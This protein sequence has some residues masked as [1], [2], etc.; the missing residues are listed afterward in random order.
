MDKIK[1]FLFGSVRRQLITSVALVHAIM[2]TLFVADLTARQ[3]DFLLERQAEQARSIAD[4]VAVS[5]GV[6]LLSR[7]LTGLQEIID[8]QSQHPGLIFAMAVDRDGLI[9]A[10]TERE[11]RGQYI[12]DIPSR[13]EPT[14]IHLAA[15]LTDVLT[16]VQIKNQHVGWIRI[17]LEQGRGLTQSKALTRNGLFY[18]LAA[19]LIGAVIAAYTGTRLTRKLRAIRNT[20]DAIKSGH[21][22]ARAPETGTDEAAVLARD[23]NRMLDTLAQNSQELVASHAALR[24]NEAYLNRVL[25]GANDGAWEWDMKTNHVSYSP[26]WKSML[27]Y[28]ENELAP[29]LSTW[30]KLCHPDDV[31]E[32]MQ[33]IQEYVDGKRNS[34]QIE[35]RMMHK[36]GHWVPVL[37]RGSLV[38]DANGNPWILSGTHIDLTER[39]RIEAERTSLHNQLFQAQKMDSIGHLTGGIAHD[40]NN[41]LGAILGYTELLKE[42]GIANLA[43]ERREKYLSEILVAANRA[44]ELISQML[45][46]SRVK[47]DES[48]DP[49]VTL[50]Q[51]VVKEVIHLLRSSLPTTIDLNYVIDSQSTHAQIHPVHLHQILLNLAINARDAFQEYG[52]IDI[53]IS[54]RSLSGNCDACHQDFSGEF[55]ELSVRDTG[56]G[57][58]GTDLPKIFDPFFTT[59][60]VGK[61][62]GMGLSVVHGLVHAA[63]GHI[64]VESTE[65]KGSLFRVLLPLAE[66][67]AIANTPPPLLNQG[68]LPL[69]GVRIM[70]VD[71]EQSMTNMLQEMLGLQGAIVSAYT[72][73]AAALADFERNP[74]NFDLVL[75]DE[76]MPELSGFDMGRGMLQ[77]RSELPI[78]LCTGYSEHV[79]EAMA[80]QNGFAA[81][82]RKPLE[83]NSLS[84]LARH[85]VRGD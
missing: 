7:D 35:F 59:K 10:H 8:A 58:P 54:R 30:E 62:T 23:F 2:M 57:I 24:E 19:I 83:I 16:P 70:V 72:H 79:N 64:L 75:T 40:F 25:R 1:H 52:R 85:L 17:G 12:T 43:P 31:K 66:P 4:S 50:L 44:K 80:R 55:V 15:D 78:I 34:F 21:P 27:G 71:D 37:S 51:P 42:V 46:F 45:L 32:T 36:D 28:A 39:K 38:R 26:R 5:S 81:F 73:S 76:T 13:V 84:K 48:A 11:R 82:L 49:P 60:E 61:G 3:K 20:A 33:V 74:N 47:A 65:G 56:R 63:G 53:A 67:P 6:W 22:A 14:T 18:A 9:L 69:D 68:K 41:I 77:L 29:D